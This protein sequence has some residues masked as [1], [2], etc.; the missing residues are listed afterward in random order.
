[1]IEDNPRR[2]NRST[3]WL[4]ATA[5]AMF[6]VLAVA[7]AFI[8]SRHMNST[9]DIHAMSAGRPGDAEPNGIQEQQNDK[10]ARGP[11]TTGSAIPNTAVPPA[12]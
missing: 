4:F 12:K 6:V 11:E 9:A 2:A 3:I 10:S 5:A 7:G 8:T 1:M